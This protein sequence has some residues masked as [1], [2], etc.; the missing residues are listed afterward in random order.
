[1]LPLIGLTGAAADPAGFAN[2]LKTKQQQAVKSDGDQA[3]GS[4]DGE[5]TAMLPGSADQAH[6]HPAAPANPDAQQ[7]R[8]GMSAQSG[9]TF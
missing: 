2:A 9:T 8:N 1:M 4:G 7:G 5:G 3:G 6:A